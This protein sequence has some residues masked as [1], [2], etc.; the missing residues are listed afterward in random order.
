MIARTLN[1]IQIHIVKDYAELSRSA[2]TLIMQRVQSNPKL[3]VLVPTGTTPEG[4][5]TLLAQQGQKLK[6]AMF[7]NMD[8]Y[9]VKSSDGVYTFL[10]SDDKRSY[11]YYM[12]HHLLET[13]PAVKSYFPGLENIDQPGNYDQIIEKQGGLDFCLNAIGED[14]HTFGFN[15]PGS[16]FSSVTRLV[17][18]NEDTQE[19]NEK[20]TGFATPQ[21]AVTVGLK[22]GMS[23]EEV[24]VLVSGKRKA[25][26]LRKI[27]YA[28]M[29]EKLP[30]TLL[31]T[32]ARCS[33]IVDEDAAR[34]LF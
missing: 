17:A 31:K 18:I 6:E 11:H 7:Y 5:Y 1:G 27:L 23:A 3:S 33:W 4:V 15:L 34:L 30:A 2:A 19:V 22:T 28:E 9:C 29:T 26:I 32:H 8:E 21:Y 13:L 10:P 20:L 25:G 12:Q 16:S 24:V 14:G